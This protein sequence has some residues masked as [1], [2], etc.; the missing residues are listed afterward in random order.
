[1]DFVLAIVL[2]VEELSQLDSR[3]IQVCMSQFD[4]LIVTEY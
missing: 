4:Q 3:C 1:M 2:N